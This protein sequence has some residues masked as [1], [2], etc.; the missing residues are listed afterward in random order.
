MVIGFT[1]GAILMMLPVGT[2]LAGR[3]TTLAGDDFG[4]SEVGRAAFQGH[5]SG[6]LYTQITADVAFLKTHESRDGAMFVAGDPLY[7]WLSGRTQAITL[8]GWAL[9]YYFQDQWTALAD[10]V[11][12]AMPTYVFIQNN[13]DELIGERG[14]NLSA[15]LDEKYEVLRVSELGTWFQVLA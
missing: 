14:A 15:V 1:L 3:L 13:Y 7:Y 5:F 12:T 9:E 2:A 11:E 8:N 4:T 10:Q 6:D